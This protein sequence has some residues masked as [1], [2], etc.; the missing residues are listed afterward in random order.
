M[1]KY[2]IHTTDTKVISVT[3]AL[4]IVRAKYPIIPGHAKLQG[5][6]IKESLPA[7]PVLVSLT[8]IWADA[9][10]AEHRVE[11][12]LAEAAKLFQLDGFPLTATTRIGTGQW[13][14][15]YTDAQDVPLEIPK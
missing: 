8:A 12:T 13:A 14:T 5:T 11:F 9:S 2:T 15:V 1:P 10:G 6:F 3:R 4:E 7:E